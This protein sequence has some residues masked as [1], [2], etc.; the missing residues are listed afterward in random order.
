[1]LQI[2]HPAGRSQYRQFRLHRADGWICKGQAE[3]VN[4]DGYLKVRM[5]PSARPVLT[6]I[7]DTEEEFD[8]SDEFNPE[9]AEVGHMERLG[10]FQEIANEYGV[11][12]AYLV[13]YAIISRPEGYRQLLQYLDR[14]Q[15]VLGAHLHP[16]VTPPKVEAINRRNSYPGN[17]PPDLEREK[18]AVLTEKIRTLTGRQPKVYKAGRYGIGP[19]SH[20]ILSDLGYEVDT[21]PAPPMDF[22]GDGGPDFSTWSTDLSWFGRPGGLLCLP[23]TGAFTGLFGS[24]APAV[25]SACNSRR[26]RAP[27]AGD[28]RDGRRYQGAG[29]C[30]VGQAGAVK[31]AIS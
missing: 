13:T 31:S 22:T 21:S 5:T 26:L 2:I 25:Y 30:P 24:A 27:L 7:V 10:C 6:V 16:W 17:L 9:A 12:P 29:R 4:P 11:Q 1:M 20:R 23:C 18:L 3:A 15:A 28:D 14:N 19:A 8:W